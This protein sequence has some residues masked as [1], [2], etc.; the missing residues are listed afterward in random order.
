MNT[1][2]QYPPEQYRGGQR[3]TGKLRDRHDQQVC[4]VA[5]KN[6]HEKH[7]C[8]L[9]GRACDG[10]YAS[11]LEANENPARP[12]SNRNEGEAKQCEN[13]VVR[14]R[15]REKCS[16]R[17]NRSEYDRSHEANR[18]DR[19]CSPDRGFWIRGHLANA[20]AQIYSAVDNSGEINQD[21]SREAN[22][23]V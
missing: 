12:R 1:M 10:Y 4:P 15:Q 9:S 2:P 23:S 22:R 20:D 21:R 17:N 11:L 3:I 14:V 6:D 13:R 5:N 16:A 7:H 19:W 8:G 18:D